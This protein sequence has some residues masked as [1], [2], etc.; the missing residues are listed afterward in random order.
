ML[1]EPA[2][3]YAERSRWRL[4]TTTRSTIACWSD[5]Y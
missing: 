2:W 3:V 4:Q 5:C 1:N